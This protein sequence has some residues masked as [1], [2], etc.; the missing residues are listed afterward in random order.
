MDKHDQIFA[1]L[2]FNYQQ[3]GMMALGKVSRPDG[4]IQRNL[5]EASFLIDT[6]EM[7]LAK[8]KGNVPEEL[9]KMLE[10]TLADLRLNYVEESNKKVSESPEDDEKQKSPEDEAD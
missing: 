4:Q 3:A 8:T 1:A 2:V 10:Q 5:E 6:L 7:L 9:G